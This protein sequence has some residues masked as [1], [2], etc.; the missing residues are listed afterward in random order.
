ML[1]EALKIDGILTIVNALLTASLSELVVIGSVPSIC[2]VTIPLNQLI[3]IS[4]LCQKVEA[5]YLQA[6]DD[7]LE[8]IHDN[9]LMNSEERACYRVM[10][11]DRNRSVPSIGQSHTACADLWQQL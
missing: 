3:L 5:V 2:R 6:R 4:L 1:M 11:S 10:G 8:Y 9:L 7:F